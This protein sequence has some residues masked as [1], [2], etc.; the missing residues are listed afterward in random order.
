MTRIVDVIISKDQ[1]LIVGSSIE[2]VA[3]L[4]DDKPQSITIT[5]EDGGLVKKVTSVNMSRVNS[6]VYN[7]IFQSVST[8]NY[9]T[10]TAKITLSDGTYTTYREITF[11]LIDQTD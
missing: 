4:S 6:R 2:I 9:G 1:Q 3:M 7:Y 11:D 10:Y 8:D 5:I